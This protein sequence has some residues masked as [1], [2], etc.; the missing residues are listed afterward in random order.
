MLRHAQPG[1][2]TQARDPNAIARSPV[3]RGRGRG[4]IAGSAARRGRPRARARAVRRMQLATASRPTRERSETP[5]RPPRR[6]PPQTKRRP[7]SARSRS[8]RE[9][10]KP[11]RSFAG[12]AVQART[13]PTRRDSRNARPKRAARPDAGPSLS[14]RHRHGRADPLSSPVE[15]DEPHDR[16]GDQT[17]AHDRPKAPAPIVRGRN[18]EGDYSRTSL[19]P[20]PLRRR[21]IPPPRGIRGQGSRERGQPPPIDAVAIG[22]S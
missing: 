9:A 20:A 8:P 10:G 22:K 19:R 18:G 1:H 11:R 15:A 5:L 12:Y 7:P 4:A 14:R 17:E 16:T 13:G 2:R 6:G 3:G 21:L